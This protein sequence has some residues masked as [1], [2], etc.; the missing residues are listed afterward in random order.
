MDTKIGVKTWKEPGQM[1]AKNDI[2]QTQLTPEQKQQLGAENLG[3]VIN[4]VADPS[5][6]DP[7]KKV[8][9]TGNK[10]MD[11]DAFFKLMLAQL[12]NQ[13]PTNPLKNHEM[14][15]QLAQFSSLEQ[16]T[17]VNKNLQEMKNGNKPIEQFQ[18]LNLIGK[19]VSGD[20]S[21]IAR[22]DVD[23]EHDF[24][25]ALPQDAATVKVRVMNA[26]GEEMR[27]YQF[28]QLKAGENKVTWNGEAEDGRKTPAGD[29]R[30]QIEAL[31][32]DGRKLA[33]KNDFEG[34]VSGLS[35][36]NEGPILQ[37]GKQ[38]IRLRDIRQFTDPSLKNNDQNVNDITSQD[39]KMKNNSAQTNIKQETKTEAQQRALAMS[40]EESFS[41]L[42]MSGDLMSKIKQD[43]SKKDE[44]KN[45]ADAASVKPSAAEGSF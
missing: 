6:T 8:K 27:A 20:A 25:F 15:A 38:S 13:D 12:K 19:Q 44:A 17:N 14:A 23:K 43:M 30:F 3:E 4:K 21:K 29:Y 45:S 28:S 35:F 36:S 41:D 16:M 32:A 18:A 9:G 40:D 22:T 31:T 37:V 2:Q 26:R 5:W 10:E 39:L 34:V 11:K 33:V 42:N 1:D 7:S 24:R